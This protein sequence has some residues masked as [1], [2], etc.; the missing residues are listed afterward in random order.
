[1]DLALGTLMLA[2]AANTK[3]EGLTAA[4]CVLG[5]A[6][7][8]TLARRAL[9]QLRTLAP[10]LLGFA[11]VI[12]PWRLWIGAHHIHGDLPVGKGLSRSFL[13]SRS[14]RVDPAVSSLAAHLGDQHTLLFLVPLAV[15]L[16]AAGLFRAQLRAV[17]CFYLMSGIGSF[18]LLVWAYWISP[19]RLTVHL[20]TS[21]NRVVIGLLMLSVAAILQ[22]AG[23]LE[24]GA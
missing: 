24:R 19:L 5:A 13:H 6:T 17:A 9:P 21:A 16:C 10:A 1:V 15:V 2:A 3:N 14:W 20:A 8:V 23:A 7:V 12:L 11:A 18:L 4:L 22:L